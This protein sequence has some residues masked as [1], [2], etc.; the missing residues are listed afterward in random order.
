MPHRPLTLVAVALV[1]V[2][3]ARADEVSDRQR[4]AA[5]ANLARAEVAKAT[6]VETDNLILLTPLPEARAKA[7]AGLVQKTYTTAHKGLRFDPKE[8]PWPGRLAVY[9]LPERAE[10]TRFMRAVA[11]AK[12][13]EGSHLAARGENAYV[14][15]G[16]P[17]PPRAADADVAADL[18]PLVGAALLVAR[19]GPA[20]RA[21]EWVRSGYGRAAALRAEGTG[22]K[23][24]GEYRKAA[25]AAALGGGGR[26][27]ARVADA[28]TAER[29]DADVVATSVIDYLAF[30]PRSALFPKFL[31]ALKPDEDGNVP[32]IADAV[33]AAAGRLD[34]FEAG[35]R[36]WVQA[37]MVVK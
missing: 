8:E 4:K 34:A 22:G 6:V 29:P 12:P 30:G 7:V 24:F 28:W 3:L 1:G 31:D 5:E 2:G 15:S 16:T 21:P 19:V 23:R 18:G 17:L 26:P 11:G 14:L 32:D 13:D 9:H 33:E 20:A 25:R 27:P 37:G 35:W 36:R 10:F